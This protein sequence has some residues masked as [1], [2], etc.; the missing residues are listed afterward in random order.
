[1]KAKKVILAPGAY[2]N[3]NCLIPL[4]ENIE[5][6][7]DLKLTTQTVAYLEVSSSEAQRLSKMPT[8]CTDYTF[9]KLD[10]TYILPPILYPDGKYYLKLGHGDHFEIIMKDSEHMK[11]WYQNETGDP[12]A[13]KA[14]ASFIAD[15]FIPSLE[16]L[17]VQGGCC[18]TSNVR[19]ILN[20]IFKR[21]KK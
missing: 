8:I 1:M 16:V 18:V 9:K 14:L 7:P 4:N 17:S 21:F 10:G 2:T 19:Q 3:M 13:V 11:S 5:L 15:H 20:C 6:E 12:E